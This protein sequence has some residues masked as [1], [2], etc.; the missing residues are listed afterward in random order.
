MNPDPESPSPVQR[1]LLWLSLTCLGLASLA[2][3]AAGM[4]WTLARLIHVLSPVLWPLAVAA[5]LACL[6][7]PVVAAL[8]RR[9]LARVPAILLVFLAGMIILS[10]TLASVL[11]QLI[12]ETRQLAGKLP[13]YSERLTLAVDG[14]LNHPPAFVAHWLPAAPGPA[15]PSTAGSTPASNPATDFSAMNGFVHWLS[16]QL[17]RLGTW[18]LNRLQQVASGFAILAGL[19]LVPVYTFYFLLE[20]RSIL[21]R[22]RDC[23]P[24]THPAT[25]AELIFI[26]ESIQQYLVAFFR[27]QV[28]VAMADATLYTFGFLM[29]G[30]NYAFLLGFMALFLTMIPFLGAII[31]C[32]TAVLLAF[33]Q[34]TDFLHPACTIALFAAVQ[35]MEGLF[36]SP[37]I[38]GNRV[39]LHPLAIIV[40]VMTGTTLLGGL[41]GGVLAIPLAAALRV[42]A[43]RHLAKP[44]PSHTVSND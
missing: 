31:I 25:R 28:L 5:I 14:F 9:G 7:S 18:L 27:G 33:V 13:E 17:P 24:V 42:I 43:A 21:A 26:L 19:F 4:V 40:A 10:G 15:G 39:G 41:L 20:Q 3:L 32:A 2:A 16:A 36:I 11:P 22:W 8:E 44:A 37:R 29:V 23:L 35:A 38:M 1:R 34:F 30:I 12:G 6:L